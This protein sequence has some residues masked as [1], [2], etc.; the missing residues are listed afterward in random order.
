VGPSRGPTHIPDYHEHSIR[1]YR[2]YSARFAPSGNATAISPTRRP[3]Q[4]S[5]Q[6]A[7]GALPDRPAL[8]AARWRWTELLK[9][10]FEVDP[11]RCVRCG[12]EMRIIS[13]ALD[14]DVTVTI[15]RHLQRKGR[16][17]RALPDHAARSVERAP[18]RTRPRSPPDMIGGSPRL[19]PPDLR[20]R[21]AVGPGVAAARPMPWPLPA[22]RPAPTTPRN[23]FR[24][25]SPLRNQRIGRVPGIRD[26]HRRRRPST[27][28][29][30]DPRGGNP[31]TRSSRRSSSP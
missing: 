13:F 29:T 3:W 4:A 7:E 6:E 24:I 8:R 2:A 11:L 26:R 14:P 10:I 12:D 27:H 15:L 25:P 23:F 20:R 31:W 28:T 9:R 19:R 18:L 30:F 16:D 17:P 21:S 1:A 22:A 5:S